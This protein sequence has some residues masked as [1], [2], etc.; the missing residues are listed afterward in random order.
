[1]VAAF[2]MSSVTRLPAQAPQ[3]F[4]AAWVAT[5]DNI[6][7]PSRPGLPV[8]QM[9]REMTAILDTLEDLNM[10]AM[11][12]Q[13]RP[14]ADSMY[15]S[16]LEP[17][18]WFLTGEQGQ[19]PPEGFDPLLWTIQESHKRGIEVHVW[20]NPYRAKHFKQL[21]GL[22]PSH[23][24]RRVPGVVKE[25]GEYLWMDPGEPQVQDQSYA[26][27]MDLVDRYDLDGIHIDDYFYPYPVTANGRKV[28][29]PDGPSWE[30]YRRSGG[31]LKRDD[32]RRRNVDDFID[33]VHSG[34]KARKP[35]VKFGIS[36]FGIYRPEVPKGIKAGIDQYAELYADALKWLKKGWADYYTPQL[37][38]PIEQKAQSFT[39]LLDWW[40]GQTPPTVH[41]WPG[42]YTSR[43]N[44]EGGNWKPS[45]VVRQI[46]YAR[47]KGAS[48]TVHFSMKAL[49]NDWNGIANGLKSDVYQE[50]AL[51][52]ASPWLDAR[53]PRLPE[54]ASWSPSSKL[55]TISS[56]DFD[57]RFAM[58][59]RLAG[60]AWKPLQ[61]LGAS[62][63]TVE[64]SRWNGADPLALSL[65]D[66]VG[67]ES[68]RVRFHL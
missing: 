63:G 18:S 54:V 4:R 35:W 38:W 19:A 44:P 22:H 7:W 30:A 6:D 13:V 34:I 32:W 43:T 45:Q 3:E 36:P 31:R 25:Y 27:F 53:P 2:A 55:L 8:G 33:R 64:I 67:N 47:R 65:I 14:S 20:L 28:D 52:P 61:R 15:A 12:F 46:Q 51:V 42:Q 50:P 60:E 23:L 48:G 41:L 29:F 16:K 17:W 62:S 56:P 58:V 59:Y 1:M 66:R 26:V 11:I 37:Y 24:H 40:K 21:G 9:K 5:V 68:L 39:A 57:A 10:N 49:Q